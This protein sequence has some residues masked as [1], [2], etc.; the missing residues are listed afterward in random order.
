[1]ATRKPKSAAPPPLVNHRWH[2]PSLGVMLDRLLP[3]WLPGKNPDFSGSDG[4]AKMRAAFQQFGEY[5]LSSLA[6]ELE[7]AAGKGISQTLQLIRDPEYHKTARRRNK[8]EIER[9]NA[10]FAQQDRWRERWKRCEFTQDERLQEIGRI[11]N[12]LERHRREY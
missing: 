7:K 9:Q 6:F 12:E 8:K 4:H 11:A 2:L 1:M 5:L 10:A 3:E